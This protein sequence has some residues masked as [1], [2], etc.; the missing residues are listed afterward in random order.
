[1]AAAAPMIAPA[2]AMSPRLSL[3][4]KIPLNQLHYHIRDRF[5]LIINPFPEL[6]PD[7]PLPGWNVEIELFLALQSTNSIVQY[8]LECLAVM[9]V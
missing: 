1:M 9:L 5:P 6:L 4:L 8:V 7:L 2:M 3:R